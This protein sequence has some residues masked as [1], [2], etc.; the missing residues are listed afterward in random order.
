MPARN[1][2]GF[3]LIELL[4]VIAII[5]LL[6][7]ILFPV[8][9]R[10]REGV[11][12]ATCMSNMHDLWVA[13]SLYKEDY[14]GYPTM[15]LGGAE[16]ADGRPWTAADGVPIEM[17]RIQHGFLFPR[18]IKDIEKFHC[19]DN[20]DKDPTKVVT[21]SAPVTSPWNATLVSNVGHDYPNIGYGPY[22]YTNLPASYASQPVPFYAVDSYDLSSLMLSTGKR[23]NNS[24]GVPGYEFH[25]SKDWTAVRAR[26]L[27]P[28]QDATN[29]LEYYRSMNAGFTIL[30]WCN[31]HVT[32]A[33]G[34]KCNVIFASGTAKPLDYKQLV[35]KSWNVAN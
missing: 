20:P 19:P 30:T 28:R 32:T 18:Y 11:R 3:T 1:R 7:A 25:Y 5:A 22:T 9:G 13:A 6:A 33:G 35:Q 34:D 14:G 12:K 29:Q 2:R 27:N 8:F 26:G 17:K 15:L 10:V 4:T 23:G 16:R 24:A 31:Y 21:A